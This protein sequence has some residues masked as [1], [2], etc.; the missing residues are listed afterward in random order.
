MSAK[1]QADGLDYTAKAG[2]RLLSLDTFRGITIIAMIL[3]NT[4][5]SWDYVYAPLLHAEWHG[6]TPTDYIFPFFIFIVGVSVVLSYQKLIA[7]G[8]SKGSLIGKTLKRAALIFLIGI[9]LGLFPDFNFDEIRI[10]GVLQRIALVFLAC[11][12]L[13]LYTNW[14]Q[15]GIFGIGLL[16]LYWVLMSW[17]PVPGIGAGVLEPGKNLAAHLDSLYI[18][19]SMWQ[20]TW[21][22]EG[23]LS[24]LPAIVSGIAGMLAG[25]L[26]SDDKLSLGEKIQALFA[27]GFVAFAIGSAWG[28]CFPIN[29]NLWTSSYVL[30]TAGLAA[31]TWATLS[32]FMDVRN[33]VRWAPPAI[34]FGSNAI[35]AYAIG[36]MLPSLITPLNEWYVASFIQSAAHPKLASMIWAIGIIL[37]CFIPIWILYKRK[38]FIKV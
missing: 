11:A 26:Y 7:R 38:I 12:I 28:W 20:G 3:V 13:F 8:A 16:V 24:T 17:V 6:V 21:D 29:K 14:K 4:P 35:T 9:F 5:G 10:P 34:A 33:C 18:P 2:N 32:Y 31:M 25:R 15:Q 27:G 19:G 36:S 30:Y 23:L 37:I 1:H 22:P